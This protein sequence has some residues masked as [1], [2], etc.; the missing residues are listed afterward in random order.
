CPNRKARKNVPS[1]EGARTPAHNRRIAPCRSR[2]ISSIESAPATMPATSA[3]TFDPAAQPGPPGTVNRSP[4]RST[5]PARWANA[6]AGTS[7]ADDTSV[8][9]SNVSDPTR[10]ACDSC[11]YENAL[12]DGL[13][14]SLDKIDSLATQGHSRSTTRRSPDHA[15]DP[16]LAIAR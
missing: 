9:S 13:E 7:P 8:G 1:V 5:S 12:R 11:T 10:A 14:S 2:S 4:A 3:D 6:S 15:A 16:G